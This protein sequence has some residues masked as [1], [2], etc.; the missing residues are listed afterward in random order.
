MLGEEG[1]E[2]F[3]T[4]A[5]PAIASSPRRHAVILRRVIEHVRDQNWTAIGID[6][7]IVVVG[8]FVGLQVNNW[9]AERVEAQRR[10]QIID[11]LGTNLSDAVAVQKRFVAEIERGLSDWEDAFARGERPPPFVYRLDGSDTAPETWSTFEQ[12]QLADM[13]DPVTLFDL[14]YFYSELEGVGRKY[15]RYVTF[16]EAEVLPGVIAG[17]ETFYDADGLLR[18]QFRANMDRLREYQQENR[19]MTR[20]AECLVYRLNAERTFEQ[21][22]R[23]ANYRLD[24]MA[25][26]PHEAEVAR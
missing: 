11:A 10:E 14:T 5:R 8:V 12:M 13:F 25:D 18:P 2:S 4:Q 9:N 26:Q 16:V 3:W 23:R 24:G 6:F 15:V 1:C 21:N 17:A 7:V 19:V 22:C 20:W